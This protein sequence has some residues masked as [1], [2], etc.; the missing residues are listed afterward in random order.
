V[1]LSHGPLPVGLERRGHHED[2]NPVLLVTKE[3]FYLSNSGGER[4]GENHELKKERAALPLS[5]RPVRG[6]AGTRTQNLP[7]SNRS[8]P[9]LHIAV[10]VRTVGIEP[11]TPDWKSG[12]FPLHHVH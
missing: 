6:P 5:Y 8:N 1:G 7:I 11:T 3:V 12:M 9:L 4:Y 2:S 10:P